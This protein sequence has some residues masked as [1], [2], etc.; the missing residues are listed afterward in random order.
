MSLIIFYTRKVNTRQMEHA[1]WYFILV[2]LE[3]IQSLHI[4]GNLYSSTRVEPFCRRAR[5][6]SI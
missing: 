2:N 6:L 1:I 5:K 3:T 4:V